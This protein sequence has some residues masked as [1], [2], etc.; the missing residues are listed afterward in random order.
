MAYPNPAPY[1]V[2]LLSID[3]GRSHWS[4]A[5]PGNEF[6]IGRASDRTLV[7]D[8]PAISRVH[9]T[10][11]RLSDACYQIRDLGSRFG[12]FVNAE[13]I[14]T[15]T[16]EHGDRIAFGN[17]SVQATFLLRG[18]DSAAREL[19]RNASSHDHTSELEKLN[20]F[21]RAAR[22][23]NT[24]GVLDDVVG[25]L[26]DYTLKITGAERGFVFLRQ[27]AGELALAQGRD[28]TGARLLDDGNISRSLLDQ[29]AQ[30]NAEFFISDTSAE[31][32]I[33]ARQ[34]IMAFDLRTIVA[35]PLRSM[36]APADSPA[37]TGVLYLDSRFTSKNLSGCSA[38]I[39]R[40]IATEAA[41]VVENARLVQAEQESRQ[42][43]QELAIAS[44]IQQS[45]I[46]SELPRVP[47][48]RV[49]ARTVPCKQVGGDFYDVIL[50]PTG[51]AV[52][53]ADVSGKGISAA[54]L[55]CV[56]QGML[57][58]Q[59]AAGTPLLSALDTL[60]DFLY[61]RVKGEKYATL[62][63]AHIEPSGETEIVCCGHIP[64][65]VLRGGATLREAEASIPVG[66]IPGATFTSSHL[67]L[68]SGDRLLLLTDGITEAANLEGEEFGTHR[69]EQ[70][71]ASPSFVEATFQ[72]L[73]NFLA[74]RTAD[75]DC[76]MVEV[77][78]A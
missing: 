10:I 73:S 48:A 72:E 47:Y 19:L 29:A 25:T 3:D 12:T 4:A 56:I 16:L 75:D 67:R 60:N 9:A 71:A 50:T 52:I 26:L 62:V 66:L 1:R 78:F 74:F 39:L 22:S 54:L 61:L 49:S 55:A 68:L 33:S 45:L 23:L 32:S 28:R 21:L 34:S 11:T 58:A 53:V 76:T 38:E 27:P 77:C 30:T 44:T 64:P 13:R 18:E 14:T 70:Y 35:I 43:Q 59:L 41:R 63:I 40:A 8:H 65:M 24:T 5:I 7:L 17:S 51:M 57:Y 37:V 6:T 69:L 2:A 20:L 46:S 15:H 36:N 42:Y 31:S